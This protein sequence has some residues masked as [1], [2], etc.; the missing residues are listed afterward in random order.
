[1][2][3]HPD[4]PIEPDYSGARQL[5]QA[6][7]LNLTEEQQR[8][9]GLR[10]AFIREWYAMRRK[11]RASRVTTAELH[12]RL[13]AAKKAVGALERLVEL[14]PLRLLLRGWAVPPS[15]QSS[16]AYIADPRTMVATLATAIRDAEL[17]GPRLHQGRGGAR[18]FGNIPAREI[19]KL[20]DETYE[21]ITGKVGKSSFNP[22]GGKASSFVVFIREGLLLIE[23]R[24][25]TE[26]AVHKLVKSVRKGN[27]FL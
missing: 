21:A 7:D 2:A 16:T 1:M 19:V 5:V 8:E 13:A 22:L 17:P 25:R 20:L 3:K 4:H 27:N 23:N 12:K 26:D 11:S 6:A 14:A 10:L 15:Q 9:L 24:G 18:N